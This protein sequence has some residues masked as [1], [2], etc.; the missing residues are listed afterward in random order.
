[1]NTDHL[2][3]AVNN[4]KASI[5]SIRDAHTEAINAGNQCAEILIYDMV[6]PLRKVRDHM[7]RVLDSVEIENERKATK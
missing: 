3:F 6:E 1:M 5:A 4:L 7:Q 2:K